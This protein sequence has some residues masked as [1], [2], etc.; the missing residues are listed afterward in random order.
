MGDSMADVRGFRRRRFVKAGMTA[1]AMSLLAGQA[2]ASDC[3]LPSELTALN[4]RVLQS[5]LV[6]AALSCGENT[7]YN[8]FIQKF[9]PVLL[10]DGVNF[11][12]YFLRVYGPNGEDAM[13]QL[14]TRIA[15]IESARSKFPGFDYC[16]YA[17]QMF[18]AVLALP[19]EQLDQFASARGNA[20]DHDVMACPVQA[21]SQAQTA[22]PAPIQPQPETPAP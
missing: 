11:R 10:Q 5:E 22:D 1:A 2:M 18:S 17:Y 20:T 12:N 4:T 13:N 14:V 9:E 19:P 3:A 21:E 8:T 15:N 6:V 7:E 16:S